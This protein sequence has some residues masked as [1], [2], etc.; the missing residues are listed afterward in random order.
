MSNTE[1]DSEFYRLMGPFF[2]LK[3][4]RKTLP[5]LYNEDTITWFL[6]I[7]DD[8]VIGF[9]AANNLSSKVLLQHAYVMES[10]RKCGVWGKLNDERMKFAESMGKPLETLVNEPFL[11]GYFE[12]R[13]FHEVSRMGSYL[14]LRK[15]AGI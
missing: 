1:Y 15:D 14:R 10:K 13:G 11:I 6:A 4:Y 12:A 9:M 2:A 7:E 8:A 3:A 5:Y